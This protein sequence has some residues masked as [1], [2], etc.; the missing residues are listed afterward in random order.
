MSRLHL[1][2]R[3]AF[4]TSV[5]TVEQVLKCYNSAPPAAPLLIRQGHSVVRVTCP[6]FVLPGRRA[7]F[8]PRRAHEPGARGVKYGRA[9]SITAIDKLL[10]ELHAV[11]TALA[12]GAAAR[13][14]RRAPR[15]PPRGVSALVQRRV[16]A[17]FRRSRLVPEAAVSQAVGFAEAGEGGASG[18][19]GCAVMCTPFAQRTHEAQVLES[20]RSP[21][22]RSGAGW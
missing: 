22:A 11:D 8:L 14:E 20:A 1:G 6:A 16:C 13:L 10:K 7:R 9:I 2:A 3:R 4:F 15:F 5:L 19:A 21:C 17:R 12:R 18:A